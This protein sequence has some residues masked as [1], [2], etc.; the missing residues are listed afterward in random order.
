MGLI[1]ALAI[2]IIC[3]VFFVY[4]MVPSSQANSDEEDFRSEIYDHI[5]LTLKKGYD[6]M[7]VKIAGTNYRRGLSKYAGQFSGILE[8]EPGNTYDKNAIMIKCEDGKHIGYI[9]SDMTAEVR[10]FTDGVLPYECA[11]ILLKDK[12]GF[13]KIYY[14][15]IVILAKPKEN[16]N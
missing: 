4:S 15:G 12:D 1:I 7:E 13:G 2:F 14:Y 16:K 8:A 6:Y 3:I 9:P 11:G 10:K 5:R